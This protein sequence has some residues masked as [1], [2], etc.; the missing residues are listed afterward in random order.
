MRRYLLSATILM[1]ALV[2]YGF[3]MN[4]GGTALFVV[5]VVCELWFW[6]RARRHVKLALTGIRAAR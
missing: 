1:A 5:G 3:G 6:S 2:M 4:D